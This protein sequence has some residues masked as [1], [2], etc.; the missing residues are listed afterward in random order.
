MSGRPSIDEQI[1][2]ERA[3]IK[4]KVSFL[5]LTQHKAW[6]AAEAILKTKMEKAK[7]DFVEL[8]D[9]KSRLEALGIKRFFEIV[10]GESDA[11]TKA[12]DRLATFE[13]IKRNDRSGPD[14]RPAD[15]PSR[16]RGD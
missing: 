4:Q 10:E 6:E 9:E 5:I 1:E 13:A 7:D 2:N 3:I 14:G 11:C 16:P 8:M 15:M 12:Q